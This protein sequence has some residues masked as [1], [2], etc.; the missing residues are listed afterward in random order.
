MFKKN[1]MKILISFEK[2]AYFKIIL[3]ELKKEQKV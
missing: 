1:K 3:K 2:I